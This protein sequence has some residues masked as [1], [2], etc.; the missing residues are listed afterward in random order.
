VIGVDLVEQASA[1]IG[2]VGGPAGA[3]A[4]E[5]RVE[6]VVVDEERVVLARKLNP[7]LGVKE[8]RIAGEADDREHPGVLWLGQPESSVKNFAAAFRSCAAIIM[9]LNW[10]LIARDSSNRRP[11]RWRSATAIAERRTDVLPFL[12]RSD[13]SPTSRGSTTAKASTSPAASG[14]CPPPTSTTASCCLDPD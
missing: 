8:H 10:T 5:Q 14:A 7:G 11:R 12:K 9:W 2:P 6:R 1:R 4:V 13:H 3:D